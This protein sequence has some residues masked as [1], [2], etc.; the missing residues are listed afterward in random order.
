MKLDIIFRGTEPSDAMEKYV[1][2]YVEKFKKY[3]SKQDPDSTFVHVVLEGHFNHHMMMVEVRLKSQ[4]FD[5]VVQREGADMY[6]LIDETMKVMEQ[7]LQRQKQRVVDDLR[8]RKK[9]C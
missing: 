6:P 1:I 3:L 5:V 4:H 8:K 2:K 7:E 9:C